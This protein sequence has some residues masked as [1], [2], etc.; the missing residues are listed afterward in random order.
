MNSQER[1]AV[2]LILVD[3]CPPDCE[4]TEEDIRVI[5]EGFMSFLELGATNEGDTASILGYCG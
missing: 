2:L 5:L 4:P 3:N 1:R